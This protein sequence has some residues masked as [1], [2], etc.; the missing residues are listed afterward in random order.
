MTS[1][2]TAVKWNHGS[3]FF[4]GLYQLFKKNFEISKVY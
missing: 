1:M 2:K 3:W 4:S